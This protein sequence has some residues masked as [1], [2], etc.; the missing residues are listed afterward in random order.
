M[1]DTELVRMTIEKLASLTGADDKTAFERF[2]ASQTFK[3][4]SDHR[5]GLFT[6]TPYSLAQMIL[7]EDP[8]RVC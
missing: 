5:T 2:Y 8:L 6:Y 7:N 4:L 1:G 3:D